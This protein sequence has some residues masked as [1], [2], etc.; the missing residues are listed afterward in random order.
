MLLYQ[1]EILEHFF[2]GGVFV[3][4]RIKGVD[5]PC[6]CPALPNIKKEYDYDSRWWSKC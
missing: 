5:R 3:V 1:Q 6:L 4:G 2:S